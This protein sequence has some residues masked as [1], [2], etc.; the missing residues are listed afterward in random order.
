MWI[1]HRHPLQNNEPGAG[2][3]PAPPPGPAP[4][5]LAPAA[6][7][8]PVAT[9]PILAPPAPAPPVAAPP[10]PAEPPPQLTAVE[11]AQL[12]AQSAAWEKHEAAEAASIATL[13]GTLP[14]HQQAA[15]DASPTAEG[16]R[17]VLAAFAA[18]KAAGD[19]KP[20]NPTI[21]SGGPPAP[22]PAAIDVDKLMQGGMSV[23]QIKTK[24]PAEYDAY[25]A[26]FSTARAPSGA[27]RFL[28]VVK[29]P[30]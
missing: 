11:I 25:L 3:A 1:H 9:A 8:P 2:P 20:N 17:I 15:V 23:E 13:R 18:D 10:K 19:A 28:R 4:P 27:S 12:R 26:S 6:I 16:K 24:H 22:A 29:K 5:A 7:V 30:A 14:A 21:G